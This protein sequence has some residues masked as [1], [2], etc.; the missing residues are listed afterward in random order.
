MS[1]KTRGHHTSTGLLI[2]DAG[3]AVSFGIPANGARS[4]EDN[5]ADG[6]GRRRRH[7]TG[8]RGREH[9]R[10]RQDDTQESRLTSQTGV[11]RRRPEKKR[12]GDD[13]CAGKPKQDPATDRRAELLLLLQ[14]APPPAAESSC[15]P[16][17]GVAAGQRAREC[18]PVAMPSGSSVP[19]A[20]ELGANSLPKLRALDSVEQR[21]GSH[22]KLAKEAHNVGWIKSR[23]EAR[24]RL[25]KSTTEN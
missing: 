23:N 5:A 4:G 13:V 11:R 9:A 24:V 1:V 12:S 25:G 16:P 10:R 21:I 14:C 6:E 2:V 15:R 20:P 3:S 17:P 22:Q 8:L 7:K 19:A 18:C